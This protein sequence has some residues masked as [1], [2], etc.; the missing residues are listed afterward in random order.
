[1]SRKLDSRKS[2]PANVVHWIL[3]LRNGPRIVHLGFYFF[4]SFKVYILRTVNFTHTDLYKLVDLELPIAEVLGF[5]LYYVG[6]ACSA[7]LRLSKHVA[8]KSCVCSGAARGCF[9]ALGTVDTG[10]TIVHDMCLCSLQPRG[11]HFV[12]EDIF[13]DDQESTNLP[14][15]IL[16]SLFHLLT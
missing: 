5:G 4:I 1:M 10:N 11:T 14:E 3:T 16:P 15:G 12:A 2:D 7:Y 8:Y 9:C 6:F 13:L